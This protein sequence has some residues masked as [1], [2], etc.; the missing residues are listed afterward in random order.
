MML[1]DEQVRQM[2]DALID[3]S[4][5]SDGMKRI[6]KDQYDVSLVH[7]DVVQMLARAVSTDFVDYASRRLGSLLELLGEKI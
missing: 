6:V 2:R 3:A 1:T 5:L 4:P 7:R